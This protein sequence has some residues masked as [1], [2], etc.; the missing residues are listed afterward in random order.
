MNS[1]K[2]LTSAIVIS[3]ALAAT[4]VFAQAT[5]GK[6]PSPTPGSPNVYTKQSTQKVPATDGKDP[7]YTYSNGAAKTATPGVPAGQN[8]AKKKSDTNNQ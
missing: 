1:V 7:E 5:N 2:Y 6:D 8:A 4:P 3:S